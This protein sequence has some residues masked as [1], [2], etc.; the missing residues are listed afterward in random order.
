MNTSNF[1][2]DMNETGKRISNLRKQKNM[3]QVELA[4]R[5]NISYQAVSNWERGESMPDISKLP[6]L[7]Y[8]FGGSIDDI[9]GNS[10]QSRIIEKV[11]AGNISDISRDENINVSDIIKTAPLLK[12]IQITNCL[13]NVKKIF[14][15][16]NCVV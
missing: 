11:I 13:R 15:S 4:D 10:G 1:P 16:V 3:T 12:P 6:E 7:A 9:L 2:F 14:L 8:V 5:L